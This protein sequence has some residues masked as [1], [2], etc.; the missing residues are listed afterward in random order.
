MFNNLVESGKHTNDFKRKGSFFLATIIAYSFFLVSAGV[1][2][3]FA[4]DAHLENQSLELVALLS[5]VP[6]DKPE[7]QKQQESKPAK[8]NEQKIASR[9][10]FVARVSDSFKQPDKISST[11]SPIKEIPRGPVTIGPTYAP[12]TGPIAPTGNNPTGDNKE[13]NNVSLVKEA[14]PPPSIKKKEEPVAEKKITMVSKGVIT[15]QATSLPKPAYPVI[16]K[17]AHVSGEVKLQVVVD[18]T[19]KVISASVLSGHP[20]LRGAAQQAAMQARFTPTKLSGEP[21]KV[22]G[23]ITYNFAL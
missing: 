3:V 7:P 21:V 4:Y 5:P 20:L 11:P 6:V 2:S 18:E 8:S 12:P 16:A 22:T 14:E 15:G 9:P 1:A 17:N 19:G 13:S 10:E 23:I